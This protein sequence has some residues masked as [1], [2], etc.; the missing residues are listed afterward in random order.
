MRY[1]NTIITVIDNHPLSWRLDKWAQLNKINVFKG[2][3]DSPDITV[4]PCFIF[5]ID[6]KVLNKRAYSLLLEFSNLVKEPLN[7]LEVIERIN[8]YS[9]DPSI[10]NEQGWIKELLEQSS[11]NSAC[12]ILDDIK[13][14]T[15]PNLDYVFQIDIQNMQSYNWI[16]KIVDTAY[17]TFV[18]SFNC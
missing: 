5:I 10:I 2:D 11:Y 16:I 4:L 15:Y 9:S 6:R 13:D 3:P 18:K 7:L 8:D 1:E 17:R 12:I 14:L